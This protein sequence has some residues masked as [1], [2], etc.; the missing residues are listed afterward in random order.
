M[1]WCH[2]FGHTLDST[3]SISMASSFQRDGFTVYLLN[4]RDIFN[5]KQ[6]LLQHLNTTFEMEYRGEDL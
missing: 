5:L 2:G 4:E 3:I 1:Y 6:K